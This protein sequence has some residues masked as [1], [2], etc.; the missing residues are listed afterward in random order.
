MNELQPN[1][2]KLGGWRIGDRA[3]QEGDLIEI[4]REERWLVARYEYSP[5][6]RTYHLKVNGKIVPI[7]AGTLARMY[8]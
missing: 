3:L 5:A 8:I 1:E 6:L 4:K 2:H 7:V